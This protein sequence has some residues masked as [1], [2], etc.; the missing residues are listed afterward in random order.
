MFHRHKSEN[1]TIIKPKLNSYPGFQE[2]KITSKSAECK[3]NMRCSDTTQQMLFKIYT[4]HLACLVFI[5]NRFYDICFPCALCPYYV[6]VLV[7]FQTFPFQANYSEWISPARLICFS[8]VRGHSFTRL[9]STLI[10]MQIIKPH[11]PSLTLN[12]GKKQHKLLK[13]ICSISQFP[14]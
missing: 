1:F 14:I 11:C 12:P 7:Y 5:Y 9:S 8:V 13:W 10:N 3:T 6:L 4:K 2:F